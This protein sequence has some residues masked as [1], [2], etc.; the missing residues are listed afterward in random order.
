MPTLGGEDWEYIPGPATIVWEG[1]DPSL[2]WL[3][4]DDDEAWQAHLR[5]YRDDATVA[6]RLLRSGM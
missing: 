5:R 6:G 3:Y 2:R 4:R 1:D